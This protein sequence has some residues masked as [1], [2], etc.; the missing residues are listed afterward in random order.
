[1]S[2][3]ITKKLNRNLLI[4]ASLLLISGSAYIISLNFN[5]LGEYD[6]DPFFY[7]LSVANSAAYVLSY[8]EVLFILN[9]TDP[10][11]IEIIGNY[12][13]GTNSLEEETVYY[14]IIVQDS[15][16]Y[17]F[18]EDEINVLDV[19]DPTN[20]EKIGTCETPFYY[21]TFRK[22]V[23]LVDDRIY[24]AY[25]ST[26]AIFNISNPWNPE[27][28][29]QFDVRLANFYDVFTVDS[30][31]YIA[32][33]QNGIKILDFS[34]ISNTHGGH[35]NTICDPPIFRCSINRNN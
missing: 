7:D 1:M 15:Y 11:N 28:I 17:L 25:R 9:V 27:L 12:S 21:S 34:D 30:L 4:V 13:L 19:S 3:Q 22:G 6:P 23:S 2:P 10:S 35:V 26:F 32:D 24:I 31:A 33:N 14:K 5:V 16:A 8:D 20:V 18:S 29:A